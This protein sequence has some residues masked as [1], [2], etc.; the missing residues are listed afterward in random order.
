MAYLVERME[1][2]LRA[3]EDFWFLMGATNNALKAL[4]KPVICTNEKA[5]VNA[6]NFRKTLLKFKA[7]QSQ[8]DISDFMP[9]RDGNFKTVALPAL[10]LPISQWCTNSRRVYSITEELQAILDATSL[11]GVIWQDV[12]FPFASYALS[13]KNPVVDPEGDLFDFIIVTIYSVVED[14]GSRSPRIGL[15][16]FSRECDEYEPMTE[17]NRQN[18]RIRMRR[19]EWEHILKIRQSFAEK[20]NRICCS[21]IKLMGT[22]FNEHV[23]ST[24]ER[25]YASCEPSRYSK[26]SSVNVWDS[27]I[28]IVVGM[29]LYLK[30]LPSKSPHQSEWRPVPRSGLPDPRAISN[31]AQICTVSSCYTLTTEERVM[32]GLQGTRQEKAAYELSC[33]F[34]QGHWR[35]AP[36]YGNNPDAPKTVHVRPCI[37][38]KD[39]LREGELPGGSEAIM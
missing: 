18:F 16:F 13:L 27:M 33:H 20:I 2:C 30:T 34:R 3:W 29:C 23:L 6:S 17:D 26:D 14:N 1:K 37:V 19:G 31:E 38:R 35:R 8:I 9:P 12:S 28:R 10:A 7:S 21:Y 4:G 5:V 15:F 39:R 24:A 25:V 22:D 36:G 32:L 11:D